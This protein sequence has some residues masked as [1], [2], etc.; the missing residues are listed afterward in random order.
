MALRD[1][2]FGFKFLA[3]DYVSPVLKNIE[4]RIEAVNAQVKNTS[5]WREGAS[6]VGMVAAGFLA[7]GGAAGLA[8]KSV[9]DA[10]SG[11]NTV[12]T[13]VATAMNDG[14][15]TS[16]HLAQAQ[17]MSEKM[18]IASGI[19]AT[20][21]AQ[22]YYTARSNSLDHAQ[23]LA[24]VNIAT[25]LVIG[26]TASLAEAQQQL[27][28]STRLL[29]GVF[30]TF[31]D[32][33]RNVIPQMTAYGDQLS[34]LQTH[35]AFRGQDEVNYAMQYAIPLS[36]AA[37]VTFRD[38]NA[39]LAL[40]SEGNL[41]GAE[42]GTAY[43][44][45]LSK[46]MAGGKLKAYTALTRQGGIDVGK[47]VERL[48]AATAGL[49][50]AQKASFLHQI[51]FSERSVRGIAILIDKTNEYKSVVAD[52]GNSQG[53]NAAAFAIRQAAPDVTWGRLSAAF[54]VL[55][56]KI[57]EP[58]LGPLLSL[59]NRLTSAAAYVTALVG[60][61][62]M[63]TKFVVSFVALGAAIA[64]VTG[65]ALALVAGLLA[66]GSF[67]GIGGGVIAVVAGIGAAIAAV[68]AYLYTWHPAFLATIG[69]V[70]GD[71]G[72]V[73]LNLGKFVYEFFTGQWK[74]MFT[75]AGW[76]LVKAL[77]DGIWKA[78][79]LPARA[80]E[81]MVSKIWDYFPH[82]PAKEGPLRS[83]HRVRIVEELSRSIQPGPAL[84]AMRRTA[85]AVAIAAPMVLS[86]MMSA[87]AMAG[88]SGGTSGGGIVIQVHQ[89]IHIDGAIAGDDRKL[90]A[91]LERHGRELAAII[92][93]QVAHVTRREF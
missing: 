91:T 56:S 32:K 55:R 11:M 24:A 74:R 80:T 38:Q 8:V 16:I 52:L 90:M 2:L 92:D 20:Q 68:T 5:R 58:L 21:E 27:D 65:G 40:L 85:A 4:N 35:Y 15:A 43:A 45:M 86:P 13:H 47:S 42:A 9:V 89:E 73:L 31:G 28:P 36:K 48:N 76:N 71:V 70:V 6:N 77:A 34:K 30:Q 60:Q 59:V 62:P 61:H 46:L 75:D 25:K 78:A 7:V 64:I 33:T 66:A 44:E 18:S 81:A 22:A 41:H 79:S 10:A 49:S 17:A 50:A 29:T 12:M 83:L 37:G 67:I 1:F 82:S 57:G 88:A 23:A 54:D 14:A 84:I 39:A 26:T 72:K 3:T 69:S 93:K 51:G 19:A 87:P 53:A 63:V